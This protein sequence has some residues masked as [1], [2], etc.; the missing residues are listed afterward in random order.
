MTLKERVC[1]LYGGTSDERAISIRS[2]KAIL[3]ALSA[4]GV[5]AYGLDTR[6]HVRSEL[7]RNRPDC[8]FI[9]VHGSGGEDGSIQRVL[10][11]LKIP[12]VGS[13]SRSSL[14]AFNK[15]KAKNIFQKRKVPTPRW[16]VVSGKKLS[17]QLE[18]IKLP[19]VIKPATNGS[20]IGIK[21]VQRKDSLLQNLR[22]SVARYGSV[23]VEEKIIGRE[24]TVGILGGKALPVIE[25]KPKRF[26]YDYKAKYTKGLTEYLVPAPIDRKL[27]KQIQKVALKAHSALGLRDYSRVDILMDQRNRLFVLEA[28]SIP[29]FTETS[30]LPKAAQAA[31]ISFNQLCLRLIS[32][33]RGRKSK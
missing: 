10:Q 29:G 28:N 24:F 8:A 30:L 16:L 18:L 17:N 22:S 4:S 27:T 21:M 25:L 14:R 23:I 5:N 6:K 32:F 1:V 31:G 12:Y 11:N 15:I 19:A 20:S 26:F 7:K 3:S 13:N 9:A 2:G 33:A